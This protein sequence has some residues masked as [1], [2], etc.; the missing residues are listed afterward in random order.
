VIVKTPALVLRRHPYTETSQVVT[1]LTPDA[2]R[3]NTLLKGALRPKSPF[4]GQVDLFYT[5]ELL[6]YGRNP[7]GLPVTREA[8]ALDTR[9]RLRED[10]RACAVASYLCSLVSR[11]APPRA[12]RS[13]VYD[14]LS[15][16]LDDLA[17]NGGSIDI[18]CFQELRLLYLLGLA[19]RAD[20]CLV[21][22][23]TPPESGQVMFSARD[24]GWRCE[25]CRPDARRGAGAPVPAPAIRLVAAWQRAGDPETA[26]REAAAFSAREAAQRLL[27]SFIAYHIE[28]P[29]GPRGAALDILS[30]HPARSVDRMPPLR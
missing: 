2:G 29:P 8:F 9:A 20:R 30:R 5:C 28:M 1:W 10:W 14:W 15:A 23:A 17:A 12:T 26:R 21:C 3:I 6:Y 24:G 22:A 13:A 25:G 4:L 19:P 16:A 7:D 27:G 18:L 11:A